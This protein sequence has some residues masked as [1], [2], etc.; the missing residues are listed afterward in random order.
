M[1]PTVTLNG[2]S[3]GAVPCR[4]YPELRGMEP[5]KSWGRESSHRGDLQPFVMAARDSSR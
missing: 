1:K 2:N 3:S 5:R 4:G